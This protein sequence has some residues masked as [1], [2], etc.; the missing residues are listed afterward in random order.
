M[1]EKFA[2]IISQQLHVA[3]GTVITEETNFKQ[4]LRADSF[5]LMELVMALEDEFGLKIEDD[6]FENFETVG[7]VLE[8]IRS[9]GIDE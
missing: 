2:D 8:Y 9:Q 3:P 7:D 1:L 6:E 4:D 5:E